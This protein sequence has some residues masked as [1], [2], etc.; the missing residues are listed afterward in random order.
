MEVRQPLQYFPR[1]RRS[2]LF[3]NLLQT[4]EYLDAEFNAVFGHMRT[5]RDGDSLA[6]YGEMNETAIGFIL[7]T[8][9]HRLEQWKAVTEAING[10]RLL[11]KNSGHY[12]GLMYLGLYYLMTKI[13]LKT[14]LGA[15]EMAFN[16]HLSTF[17]RMAAIC[18]EL[19]HSQAHEK[20]PTLSFDM[21]VVPPLFF[22]TLKCRSLSLRRRAMELLRLAPAQE[23]VWSRD[24]ILKVCEWKVSMEEAGRGLLPSDAFLPQSARIYQEHVVMKDDW[25]GG[26]VMCVQFRK[27]IPRPGD[28]EIVEMLLDLQM[29]RSMGNML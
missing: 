27:G 14:R 24:S 19:I 29:A 12:M 1:Q 28:V 21:G 7:D 9:L 6:S 26:S 10:T 11:E 2:A 4:R 5:V 18:D 15:S 8:H 25:A 3:R 23:G 20:P 13:I 16:E 17:E 22:L